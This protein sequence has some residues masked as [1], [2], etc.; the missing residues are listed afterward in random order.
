MRLLP[1]LQSVSPEEIPRFA[2]SDQGKQM[3]VLDYLMLLE[4]LGALFYEK[5]VANRPWRT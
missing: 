3:N 4:A 2:G 1:G 5:E